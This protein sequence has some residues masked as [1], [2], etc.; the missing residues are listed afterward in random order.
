MT[1]TRAN[2]IFRTK[3]PTGTIVRKY[4][5]SAGYKYFVV[6]KEG[7]KVYYYD[8][9]SYAQLLNS[10]GFNVAYEHD[11]RTAQAS[12]ERAKAELD[13]GYE[14]SFHLFRSEEGRVLWEKETREQIAECEEYLHKLQTEFIIENG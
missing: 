2:E 11:I 9:P 8:R 7:G 12:L 1:E 14:K 13:A 6:F 4:A 5:S 3:Y 10:L